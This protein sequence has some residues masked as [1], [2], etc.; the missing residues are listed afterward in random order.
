[1]AS[2]S[3]CQGCA[4]TFLDE[5]TDFG[6]PCKLPQALAAAAA[7]PIAGRGFVALLASH[8]DSRVVLTRASKLKLVFSFQNEGQIMAV[9]VAV[10]TA[11]DV[12]HSSAEINA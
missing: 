7:Q 6:E 8:R 11:P 3:E 2:R 5:G 4:G 9:Q 1:M 10:L 12:K